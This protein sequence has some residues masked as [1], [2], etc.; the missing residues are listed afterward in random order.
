[1]PRPTKSPAPVSLDGPTISDPW[2]LIG[3]S[4]A[5]WMRLWARGLAPA[6]LSI[7]G[8]GRNRWRTS[9]VLAYLEGLGTQDAPRPQPE[10][11]RGRG[12]RRKTG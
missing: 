2:R 4:R 9:D 7:P 8:L 12:G 5:T 3:I 1:M 10:Y 6:P 11:L